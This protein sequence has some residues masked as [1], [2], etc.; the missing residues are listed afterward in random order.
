MKIA[1]IGGGPAGLYFAIS[2]KLR[3]PRARDRDIRAQRAGRHLRLGRR[4]LRPDRREHHRATTRVSAQDHRRRVRALGRHRRPLPRRDDHLGRPR[5]HRHRPQAPA[6]NPAGPR[7][8]AR[9]R[10]ALRCR[11]RSGRPEV[12]RLRSRHRLRRHQL[13]L[14]R[15]AAAKRSELTSTSAPTSSCGSARRRCSTPSPSRS[16][17]P[18]TA[19]SGR[20]P[21]ASRPTA[22]PSSSNVRKRPGAAS[23]STG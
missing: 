11:V 20:T 1:C 2:M 10:A 17:R 6:R 15:R 4:L 16:R 7:A 23:A 3:D 19:G 14:P 9:R 8:R 22:R 5:L 21:T 13:A 18:S 12:A